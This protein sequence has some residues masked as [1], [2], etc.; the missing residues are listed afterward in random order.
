VVCFVRGLGD[1]EDVLGVGGD[2]GCC[3]GDFLGDGEEFLATGGGVTGEGGGKA[4]VAA[5]ADLGVEIDGAEE[6]QVVLLGGLL[7]HAGTEDVD[8]CA[9]GQGHLAHVLDQ[10]EDFY[11]DLV[12]HLKSFACVLKSDG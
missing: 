3:R 4:A 1:F 9:V 2:F 8:D 6:G 10:A 5:F 7:G 11:V 12:E